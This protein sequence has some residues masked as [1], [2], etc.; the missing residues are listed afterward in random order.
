MDE[1][2]RFRLLDIL[3][4]VGQLQI[5]FGHLTFSS[6]LED[7]VKRAASER[8]L[9]IIS[10]AS[11]HIPERWKAAHPEIPWKQIADMGNHLRHA[12]HSVDAEI[13]WQIHTNGELDALKTSVE[14]LLR[15]ER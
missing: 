1:R 15:S 4:A 10:E 2:L 5:L 6:F 9:E 13:L 11:R 7:R 8:F 12:Y 3:D 14:S